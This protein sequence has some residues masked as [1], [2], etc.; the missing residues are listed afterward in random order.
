MRVT[1]LIALTFAIIHLELVQTHFQSLGCGFEESPTA[2]GHFNFR[3]FQFA[4]KNMSWEKNLQERESGVH[5]C[6][7]DVYPFPTFCR[8]LGLLS[9]YSLRS[10]G[11]R[12]IVVSR[13]ALF[14]VCTRW[15]RGRF[16]GNTSLLGSRRVG[17]DLQRR[18]PHASARL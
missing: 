15:D 6:F 12:N 18:R 5:L 1:R 4:G 10:F 14:T 9:F 8:I 11:L 16:G 17:D 7:G 13:F 2:V 3:A